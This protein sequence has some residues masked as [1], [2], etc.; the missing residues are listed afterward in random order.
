[1]FLHL[2]SMTTAKEHGL[3]RYFTGLPCAKGHVSERLTSNRSCE[4]CSYF[5]SQSDAIR[6]KRKID[7]VNNKNEVLAKNKKYRQTKRAKEKR[8]EHLRINKD[9]IRN[10]KA[11]WYERNQERIRAHYR[12]SRKTPESKAVAKKFRDNNKPKFIA[13]AISRRMILAVKLERG[14]MTSQILGYTPDMLRKRIEFQFKDGMS[15]ENYGEWHI[16]HKKPLSRF[17]EQGI[18][19]PKIVNALSN[20]QPLWAREN[21][22]KG[23]RF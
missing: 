14:C 21:R 16:D 6:V 7:Y 19:D 3:K 5:K 12:A 20:L 18:T 17:I 8:S 4:M 15:W 10:K 23:K 1:M 9:R 22:Q 13:R 2:L 11:D